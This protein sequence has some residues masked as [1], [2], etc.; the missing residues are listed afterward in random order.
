MTEIPIPTLMALLGLLGGGIMGFTARTARFCTFGAIEDARLCSDFRR[1][2][3]WGLAIAVALFLT[4]A[5]QFYGLI[6]ITQA[7]HLR[8]ELTWLSLIFGGLI[9]GFG[10]A[11]IGT[12]PFGSLVRLGTGDL[13]ALVVLFVIGITGYMTM[14]GITAIVRAYIL[15]PVHINL[16]EKGA[17]SLPVLL[18]ITDPSSLFLISAVLAVLLALWAF[19]NAEFRARK[20]YM[21]GGAVIGLVVAGG[22]FTT[23][24]LGNDDFD[25]QTLLSFSFISAS[26]NALVYLMTYSGST[27]NFG[28]GATGGVILGSL[29]ASLVKQEFKLEAFD[30]SREMRRY[31]IGAAMMGFG[32]ITALGCTV[33]QGI[34]GLSTLSV[35]SIMATASIVLG[36][37]FG[38]HYLL[39]DNFKDTVSAFARFRS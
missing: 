37:I 16:G 9:F 6:D 28:V 22:W 4:A 21:L 24:Y 33:G 13:R 3:A 26:A 35:G 30:D 36:A 1:A 25:P 29:I 10:M 2:R 39:E 32:G 31:L 38:L 27:I 23:G 19:S 8:P 15:D 12:C 18:G 14:R 17:Q 20:G 5:M 34:T 7:V 11:Q